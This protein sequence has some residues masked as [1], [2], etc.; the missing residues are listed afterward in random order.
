MKITLGFLLLTVGLIGTSCKSKKNGLTESDKMNVQVYYTEQYC[1]G[2]EPPSEIL[3]QMMEAKPYSDRSVFIS[4]F[5]TPTQISNEQEVK[6]DKAGIASLALDTGVQYLVSFYKLAD[7][8]PEVEEGSKKK[9]KK[10]DMQDPGASAE[11]VPEISEEER[12]EKQW[13]HMTA[14]PLRI[15]KGKTD[16]TLHI[17]KECNPCVPPKP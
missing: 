16:Y 11:E 15:V 5:V 8:I 9:K 12:C 6:L 10:T 1:G 2:A 4:I 7:P 3:D 13:K 14:Y 17:N